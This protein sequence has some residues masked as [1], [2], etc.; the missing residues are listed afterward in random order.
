MKTMD[1][2]KR[3]ISPMRKR[4]KHK[5]ATGTVWT[6]HICGKKGVW[7]PQWSHLGPSVW[8]PDCDTPAALMGPGAYVLEH[9][10]KVLYAG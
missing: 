7:T 4:R 1:D 2:T 8:C 9:P 3:T 6:C 10:D 5:P